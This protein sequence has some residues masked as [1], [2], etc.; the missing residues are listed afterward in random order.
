MS[1]LVATLSS[2]LVWRFRSRAALELEVVALPHQLAVL[3]RRQQEFI[4][5]LN[6]LARR[7]PGRSFI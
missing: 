2:L 7:Y 5:F 4:E 6:S 3:R 1:A